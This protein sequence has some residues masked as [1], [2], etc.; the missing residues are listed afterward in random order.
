[1]QTS[2]RWEFIKENKKEKEGKHTLDQGS[3][4][5]DINQEKRRKEMENA[6]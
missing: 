6:N 2:L 3:R 1:M 4:K 5:N